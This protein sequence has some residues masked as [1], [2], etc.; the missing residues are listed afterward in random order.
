MESK[1]SSTPVSVLSDSVAIED[2]PGEVTPWAL[3]DR[4]TGSE[5]YVSPAEVPSMIALFRAFRR[6]AQDENHPRARVGEHNC[7]DNAVSHDVDGLD[8]PISECA[9]CG[10]MTAE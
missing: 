10:Q 9:V 4:Q 1:L 2:R 6:A 7:T 5:I 8:M 3:I